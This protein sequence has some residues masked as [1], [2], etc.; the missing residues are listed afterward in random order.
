M[1]IFKI[2]IVENVHSP[3][4]M[5]HIAARTTAAVLIKVISYDVM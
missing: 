1:P 4:K 5:V 2:R 3:I